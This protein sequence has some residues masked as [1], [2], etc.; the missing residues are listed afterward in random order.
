MRKVAWKLWMVTM[1]IVLVSS[2]L[3][4]YAVTLSKDNNLNIHEAN[5]SKDAKISGSSGV[6]NAFDKNA[7]SAWTISSRKNECVITFDDYTDVNALLIN[8]RGFNVKKYS[9]YYNDG[10]DW[11]LCY[12]QNEIGINRLATFYTVSAKALKIEVNEYKNT[13][14]ISDIKIYNLEKRSRQSDFRVTSYIT[15]GSLNDYKDETD[16]SKTVD[17]RCFDVVTD[18]QF[19]AYGRFNADGT[20]FKEKDADNLSILKEIIGA[21]DVNIYI[22]IFPPLGNFMADMLQNH[23]SKAVDSIVEMVMSADVDGADFDWEYPSNAAQYALYSEFLI[24]LGSRLDE[25]DKTLS[26]ALSPWGVQLSK[27]ACKAID[28]VQIMA[29]DLFD[30]NGD[31]NSYAGSTESAISYLV[32]KG[33]DLSQLNLGVS[34]Y[35]RPCDS[36]GKWYNFNDPNFEP[37]EHIMFQQGVYFN[38]PT[39][40]RDK[41][42]YGILRGLGGIMTFAQDEDLPMDHPLSLTAQ[43]G[44]AKSEFCQME[45]R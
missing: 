22:T 8:E 21:R 2:M 40:L 10:A 39:T 16:T 15:P 28:Q 35:G 11:N 3:I 19:I 6:K 26:V 30:H 37:N 20:V 18:V 41:T 45:A 44:K 12:Q 4:F 43:I 34:Y 33:F 25:L 42:I 14:K 29:Y 13:V 17:A 23:M 5:L 27:E 32:G 36:S 31:N 9:V 1:L 24:N 7:L 38:S